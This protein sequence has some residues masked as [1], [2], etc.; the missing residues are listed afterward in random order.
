M[1]SID[2]VGQ[3]LIQP[4]PGGIGRY[5]SNV[6][7]RLTQLDCDVRVVTSRIGAEDRQRL[8]PLVAAGAVLAPSVLPG[9]LLARAWRWGVAMPRGGRPVY[10][11]SLMAPLGR[12]VST[13]VTIHDAV[14]WTHPHLLTPHGA[15]WHRA[16]GA[17]A[18]RYAGAVTVPTEAVAERLAHY[19]KLGD[20]VH[21][22]PGA[23]DPS[24][25]SPA[26]ASARRERLGLPNSFVVAVGTLEP[27]KA[28]AD[29]IASLPLWPDDV[30]LVSVGQS[31]WGGVNAEDLAA[32]HGV[33]SRFLALGRVTDDDL[34]ATVAGALALVIPS[35]EEG[36]GLPI[37][38]AFALGVPVIHSDAAALVEVAGGAGVLVDRGRGGFDRRIADAVARL[39]GD[40]EFRR[41]RVERGVERAR[42]FSW[43]R[44]AQRIAQLLRAVGTGT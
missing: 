41:D 16:M 7:S 31:G 19:L 6:L 5:V 36:F 10:A 8:E 42:D 39:V 40:A 32:K 21:V 30:A 2:A 22:V 33:A 18:A 43:D 4:V 17:R 14:P 3:Q 25:A 35:L 44:S 20:R 27:R 15:S 1:L 12:G 13:V 11:P 9:P 34:A 28:L 38:E 26:D 37:L 24:W 23:V 29:A